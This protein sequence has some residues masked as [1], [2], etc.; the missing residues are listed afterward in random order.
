MIL[1][2]GINGKTQM[3]K[4]QAEEHKAFVSNST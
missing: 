4:Q 3:H 2:V 1:A